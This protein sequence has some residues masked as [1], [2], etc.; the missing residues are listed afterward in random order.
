MSNIKKF[1][2]RHTNPYVYALS[3]PI[4]EEVFYIGKG[5]GRRMYQHEREAING[6]LGSKCDRIRRI[7][8]L[9]LS[10]Q[11]S[12]L[13]EYE[14]DQEAFKEEKR[15]I[16]QY[17]GLTNIMSGGGGIRVSPADKAQSILDK[18]KPFNEWVEE[19]SFDVLGLVNNVF[20]SPKNAYSFMVNS[21][22]DV[23]MRSLTV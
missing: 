3:D 10:V 16:A 7:L 6:E 13:G 14:T 1:S 12:I 22:H 21:L 17:D 20:G 18:M 5:R 4:T 23:K 19:M 11:Y 8:E 2:R 9:G 15:F